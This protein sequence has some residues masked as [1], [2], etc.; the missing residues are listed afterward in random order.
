MRFVRVPEPPPYE[1]LCAEAEDL[2]CP[3]GFLLRRGLGEVNPRSI[4]SCKPPKRLTCQQ[5]AKYEALSEEKRAKRK[6]PA[7]RCCQF[8]EDGCVVYDSRILRYQSDGSV[9]LRTTDRR[10]LLPAIYHSDFDAATLQGEC[11]LILQDNV[12]YL[13]QTIQVPEE[14]LLEVT[15]FLGVDLGMVH[16]AVDSEGEFYDT[17]DIEKKRVQYEI[18]RSALK[19][20]RTKNSRRRLKKMSRKLAR[21]RKDVNHSVSK[22]LVHKAKEIAEGNLGS[23]AYSASVGTQ[24]LSEDFVEGCL[25]RTWRTFSTR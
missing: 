9:S 3:K 12:F 21:F 10:I 23:P 11:D 1:I 25:W 8:R 20:K 4:S 22:K 15:D 17:P 2:G 5:W 14:P 24:I 13:L 7:L 19:K 6:K 16:I 18:R